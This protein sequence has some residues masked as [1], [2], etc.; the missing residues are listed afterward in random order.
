MIDVKGSIITIDAMG[1][2]EEIA[3]KIFSKEADYVLS[4]KENQPPLLQDVTS[5][6]ERANERQYKKMIHKQK[7][8]KIHCHGRKETRRYTLIAPLDGLT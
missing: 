8:E 7:I 3:K 1:C 2:Q 6:F 5:I 4:L